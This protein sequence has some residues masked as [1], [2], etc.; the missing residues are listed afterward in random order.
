MCHESESD[1]DAAAWHSRLDSA[2]T[3]DDLL[4]LLKGLPTEK[5][6]NDDESIA[7]FKGE[8]TWESIDG[9]ESM[10]GWCRFWFMAE[11]C[12]PPD[13]QARCTARLMQ[14]AGYPICQEL[15]ATPL[16]KNLR[17]WHAAICEHLSKQDG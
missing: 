6:M 3:S 9:A 13:Q 15:E 8:S 2:R 17:R 14:E 5:P 11:W 12:L 1:F 10:L 4:S 16:N 7:R